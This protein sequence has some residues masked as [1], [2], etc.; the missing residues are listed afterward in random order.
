MKKPILLEI[1]NTF[2]SDLLTY[3]YFFVKSAAYMIDYKILKLISDLLMLRNFDKNIA[4][5]VLYLNR[6]MVN[7][8]ILIITSMFTLRFLKILKIIWQSN[9][10]W[11]FFYNKIKWVEHLL[12]F[13]H[14]IYLD[15]SLQYNGPGRKP[16]YWNPFYQLKANKNVNN[17]ESNPVKS[18][19]KNFFKEK[20]SAGTGFNKKKIISNYFNNPSKI[21]EQLLDSKIAML[22]NQNFNK[23]YQTDYNSV[24][25]QS[26]KDLIPVYLF[27]R[28]GEHVAH[29][30]FW[31]NDNNKA[32]NLSS[33]FLYQKIMTEPTIMSVTSNIKNKRIIYADSFLDKTKA[34]LTKAP[35]PLITPY[36]SAPGA[37]IAKYSS[38]SM[39]PDIKSSNPFIQDSCQ[40][41]VDNGLKSRYPEQLCVFDIKNSV[42]SMFSDMYIDGK[43]FYKNPVFDHESPVYMDFL[44]DNRLSG[45]TQFYDNVSK[46]DMEFS[47]HMEIQD[48]YQ[49]LK[50]SDYSLF[51]YM[52]NKSVSI[53]T[54]EYKDLVEKWG[55]INESNIFYN[56]I[57]QY[58]VEDLK[59]TEE[60]DDE[61]SDIENA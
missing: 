4:G 28:K 14:M 5:A 39:F 43:F 27:R 35:T 60:S 29:P 33:R 11:S 42:Q 26:Q 23:R 25:A 3:Y 20:Y 19:L 21:R 44:F 22:Y 15:N 13:K 24:F 53:H 9:P 55:F 58:Y 36:A 57:L 31:V 10:T 7:W 34:T 48:T 38:L 50:F 45:L 47:E 30:A 41:I 61:S 52:Y 56:D 6:L 18:V 51:D 17:K 1:T 16:R 59:T 12:K 8:V 49:F 32:H 2:V 40:I 46:F 54:L 37:C